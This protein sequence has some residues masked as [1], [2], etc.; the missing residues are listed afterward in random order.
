M[1]LAYFNVLTPVPG[2]ALYERDNHTG[3]IFDRDWAN[4]DGKHV[5]FSP[6]RV[7]P[8][9]LQEGFLRTRRPMRSVRRWTARR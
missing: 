6:S 2:T 4:Y 9:Q 3:R 8:E 5:V 7:T 1:E